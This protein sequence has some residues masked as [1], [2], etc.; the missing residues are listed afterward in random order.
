LP[1]NQAA[2]FVVLG[3]A[4]G[5]LRGTAQV[6]SDGAVGRRIAAWSLQKF[7]KRTHFLIRKLDENASYDGPEEFKP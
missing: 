7:I 1:K 6:R 5:E 3:L 4:S 2:D